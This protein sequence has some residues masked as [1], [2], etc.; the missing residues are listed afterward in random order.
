M[1][2]HLKDMIVILPTC[3]NYDVWTILKIALKKIT[4]KVSF[5]SYGISRS[6]I[7]N[8]KYVI[9]YFPVRN[10]DIHIARVEGGEK[11]LL[12]AE[13][14][15]LAE[16]FRKYCKFVYVFDT[17]FVEKMYSGWELKAKIENLIDEM[18]ETI[19]LFN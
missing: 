12:P 18:V 2:T 13:Y 4:K 7:K 14:Y 19:K 17:S 1:A 11:F 8:P 9:S 5:G 6:T 16:T 10:C 3:Q 15:P